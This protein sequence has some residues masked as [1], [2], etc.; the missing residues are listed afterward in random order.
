MLNLKE[1]SDGICIDRC[2]NNTLCCRFIHRLDDGIIKQG[3]KRY[4]L[5]SKT[6]DCDPRLPG[7]LVKH[8]AQ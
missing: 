4:R 8:L 7:G 6:Q 2:I 5:N 1:G 3:A